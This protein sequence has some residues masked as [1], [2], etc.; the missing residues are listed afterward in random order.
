MRLGGNL[1]GHGCWLDIK[2]LNLMITDIRRSSWG[3]IQIDAYV[4]VDLQCF[5]TDNEQEIAT[6]ICRFFLPK[7]RRA[8]AMTYHA[9]E[10]KSH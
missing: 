10:R 7:I 9:R 4:P 2:V 1:D 5:H 8:T 3:T 6:A